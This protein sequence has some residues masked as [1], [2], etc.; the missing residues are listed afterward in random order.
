MNR[1][2]RD[3]AIACHLSAFVGYIVPLGWIL[4]PLVVWLIKREE[5]SYVNYHGKEAIN[6][7]ISI[8]L[9]GVVAA[10]LTIILIGLPLLIGLGIFQI[11]MVIVA[12]VKA[13]NGEHYRYPL[14]IRFFR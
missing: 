4:G 11:I 1:H 7:Q 13:S 3:W 10:L 6:F 8:L 9:Y 5:Y 12:A 14:T 2:E